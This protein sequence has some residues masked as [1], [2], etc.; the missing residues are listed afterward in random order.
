MIVNGST[1]GTSYNAASE[2]TQ[3]NLG[4]GDNDTFAYDNMDRMNL[5]EF[6][7]NGQSETGALTWNSNG[8]L[9]QLVITDPFNS[10]DNQT[11]SYVHDDLVRISTASCG[12]VWS[13]NFTYDP[14]A[15]LWLAAAVRFRL[16]TLQPQTV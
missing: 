15:T 6:T 8:T 16:P 12:S 11:C 13:Q 4:S 2:V 5:Y 1:P 14:L 9:G 3:L 7:I 10:G